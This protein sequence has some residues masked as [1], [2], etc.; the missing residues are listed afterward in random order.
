MTKNRHP[1][2]VGDSVEL[3]IEE[4]FTEKE[5]IGPHIRGRKVEETSKAVCIDVALKGRTDK[6]WIPKSVSREPEGVN[7]KLTEYGIG[8]EKQNE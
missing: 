2:P 4:W 1:S 6:V 7:S 8:G 5:N 3:T